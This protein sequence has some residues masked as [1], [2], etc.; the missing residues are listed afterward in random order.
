MKVQSL[1][2]NPLIWDTLIIRMVILG[3]IEINGEDMDAI[4]LVA[5][6]VTVTAKLELTDCGWDKDT[7][8]K[9]LKLF[10]RRIMK[11]EDREILLSD[12]DE[13]IFF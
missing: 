7:T 8:I 2:K 9:E 13:L 11:E 12:I 5:G 4:C 6:M 3:M 10:T 1:L